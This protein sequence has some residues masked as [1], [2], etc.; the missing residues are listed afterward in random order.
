MRRVNMYKGLLLLLVA[1]QT[2]AALAQRDGAKSAGHVEI[3]N[4][5][6]WE[7]DK[8]VA[9]GAQRLLGHVRF[10]QENA[11]M[12][13]DSA[14]LYKNDRV[15]AF[16]HVELVQD[17]TL[18]I[19]G[20]LLDYNGATRTARMTGQVRLTD[21]GTELSTDALDY[22][23]K[24]NTAKYAAGAR[25]ESR[26]DGNILASRKGVYDAAKRIFTFSDSVSITGPN[27]LIT[28]DSLR[29]ATASGMAEFLGP[30]WITQ[31]DTRMYCE[32]GSYHSPTGKG[33]F[34][35]AGRIESKG[36]FLTGDSL[37]YD[38]GAEQGDGW[39]HVTLTDTANGL[40][41]RGQRGTHAQ[42]TGRSMMTGRA[43][44]VM[45]MGNDSL[46]LHADT[47]YGMRDH[48]GG[49]RVLARRNVRFFKPDMQGVCDTM[50]YATADSLVRLNGHPFL[51][52]M[53]DQLSGDT[54][55]IQLAHGRAQTLLVLGNAFLISQADSSRFNQVSGSTMTGHFSGDELKQLITEGNART[56][57]FTREKKDSVE[58]T[59]GLNRVDCSGITVGLDSGKVSTVAFTTQP[60]ATLY[61]LA[62]APVEEQQLEGFRWNAA[63]RPTDREDIFRVPEPAPADR[64]P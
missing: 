4:A 21:P 49:R 9:T 59:T 24:T 28:G 14:Y 60:S 20:D 41:V 53:Q 44:L 13:C 18:R 15:K 43:E 31:G 62:N 64:A 12:A 37:H 3:L 35:R 6:R 56:V 16:G 63:A 38:R 55:R 2:G 42:A 27:G 34:T 40:M 36:Q 58:R 10:R 5:D 11:T 61:P 26:R 48:T 17:D 25:I 22:S 30:T 1:L 47:L 8:H 19:T 7:F 50:A 51:W 23:V 57:Y 33:R 32:R 39:G 45:A 46:F 54:M 52:S 29:Y